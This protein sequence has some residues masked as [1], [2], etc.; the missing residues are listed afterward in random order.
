V[1]SRY[2]QLVALVHERAIESYLHT[3]YGIANAGWM[4]QGWFS[5]TDWKAGAKDWL[6]S[7]PECQPINS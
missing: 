5:T 6:H 7:G 3:Q 2:E 1:A 4:T